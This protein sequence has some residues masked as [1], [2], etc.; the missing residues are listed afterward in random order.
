MRFL[1]VFGI[2][3]ASGIVWMIGLGITLAHAGTG[4]VY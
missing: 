4:V 2:G 3:L 1:N